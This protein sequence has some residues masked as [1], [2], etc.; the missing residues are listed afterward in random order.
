M[1]HPSA[2]APLSRLIPLVLA[3]SV[4]FPPGAWA[5]SAEEKKAAAES[6]FDEARKLSK[7]GKHAE[8]CPMFAESQRLDPGDRK[9]VV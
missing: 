9:S 7:A 6:L 4:A 1:M 3:L 8:A 5:Q 2:H